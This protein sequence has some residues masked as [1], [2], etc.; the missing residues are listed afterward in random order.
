MLHA[1]GVTLCDASALVALL[2]RDERRHAECV[3]FARTLQ[4]RLLTTWSAF[5]EAMD[6][7]GRSRGWPAQDRLWRMIEDGA[8]DVASE[9]P[10]PRLRVL[11]ERYRDLPMA[12]ADATLVALA[13]QRQLRE[14][15]T[16]DTDFHVYRLEAGHMLHVVP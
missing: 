3:A 9:P 11:M 2:D 10:T 6:L 16:L 1:T 8:L 15:F 5:T 7:L 12:L 4:G 14:V 13:E